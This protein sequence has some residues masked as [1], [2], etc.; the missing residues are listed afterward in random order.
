MA[1]DTRGSS[2]LRRSRQQ[3]R[4]EAANRRVRGLRGGSHPYRWCPEEEVSVLVGPDYLCPA[5]GKLT[6]LAD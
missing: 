3:E 2:R 6:S 4:I 5:C 1:Y